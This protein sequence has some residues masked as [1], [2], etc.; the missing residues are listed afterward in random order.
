[1]AGAVVCG[2]AGGI[3]GG[4]L[5]STGYRQGRFSPWGITGLSDVQL[6]VLIFVF[7]CTVHTVY[8]AS[9]FGKLQ[10]QQHMDTSGTY[11]EHCLSPVQTQ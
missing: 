6:I 1:M 8:G 7:T 4:V 9:P 3:L 2:L 5:H 10:C 11:G